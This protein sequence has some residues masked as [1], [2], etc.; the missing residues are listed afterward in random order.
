[1]FKLNRRVIIGLILFLVGIS[2]FRLA[3]DEKPEVR[4]TIQDEIPKE[5]VEEKCYYDNTCALPQMLFRIQT[6]TDSAPP[7]AC[8]NDIKLFDTENIARG[9]NVAIL[10]G[11]TGDI[12]EKATFDVTASDEKLMRWL[13]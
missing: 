1:M 6:E 11:S 5:T 2:I 7:F 3:F 13:L 10:N 9:I 4:R 12:L 8:L